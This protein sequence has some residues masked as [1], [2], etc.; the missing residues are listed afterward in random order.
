M[1]HMLRSRSGCLAGLL[2]ALLWTSTIAPLGAQ[3]PEPAAQQTPAR[4]AGGEANL[5]LPDLGSVDFQGYSGRT[6]LTVGLLVSL[7]GL[8][9]V[10]GTDFDT[11]RDLIRTA[12]QLPRDRNAY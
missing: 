3:A 9:I 6:L 8:G 4:H 2:A 5:I 10:T 1:L 12:L 7:L 11:A